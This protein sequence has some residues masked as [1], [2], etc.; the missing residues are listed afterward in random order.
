M[1]SAPLLNSPQAVRIQVTRGTHRGEKTFNKTVI[2]VGRSLENDISFSTDPKVSREH[3]A[4]YI[5]EG[6]A[7]IRNLSRNSNLIV[8]GGIINECLL[9]PGTVIRVG[10]SEF[11]FQPQLTE[12]LP[13]MDLPPAPKAPGSNRFLFYTIAAIVIG[14]ILFVANSGQKKNKAEDL[15]TSEE[16]AQEIVRSENLL[17]ELQKKQED[18]GEQSVQYKMA[19]E[20]YIKG[21]RDYRN[22]QFSR[23]IQSFQAAL[24]FY[25][26]HVL[27]EKY[28]TISKRKF[29]EI[30][31]FNMNQGRKYLAKNNHRM[32]AS[33]FSKVMIMIKD[34]THPTYK[35]AK[36]L[37]DECQFYLQG[38]F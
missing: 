27:A 12:A 26:R 33:S 21:F 9:Y 1:S 38:R 11:V 16:V 35:E 23:A 36:Q 24:S 30:A 32:C 8:N 6:Q 7:W 5:E 37:F 17:K 18:S 10:D 22:G 29:D 15:R 14:A 34:P 19:Q 31:Q 2:K 4:I 13:A 25:P 20:H 28:L 3:A